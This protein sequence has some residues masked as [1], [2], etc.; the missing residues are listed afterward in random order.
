MDKLKQ[1]AAFVDVVEKGSLARAALEQSITP[2]MLGR[3]IDALEKRLGVKLM[4]RTTRHLTLTEQGSV[5]LDHCRKLLAELEFAEKI[6]SEGR[7]KAT[8]HLIV[9]AP[10]SFGRL[11]VAPHAPAFLAANPKVKVS[12]N[13]TDHVVDLVREGYELGIRI[14]GAI[15]PNFV[16]V[17][18][19]SNRRVVC[20]TPDYFDRNGIPRTLEDLSQHNCLAFNLQGGQQRGW[21]FQRDGRPVTVKVD[22]NLD[23]NDGELLH[24]WASEGLGLAWRSTWEIQ[25]QL[26]SG[27]LITVLDDYALPDY[28]IMAVYLQQRNLPAKVRFFIDTLKAVY[29][30]PGYWT[31]TRRMDN[32]ALP[33]SWDAYT[34]RS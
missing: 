2:V 28:D 14:G 12:F 17:K 23:C 16:A 32:P 26:A 29:A 33:G 21:Y 1:M 19:A 22:G 30:Q 27:Q 11:H 24:R 8:G 34:T 5:F 7:H 31:T 13:L 20:G 15:D 9:S 25:S 18:L 4:H 10:A 3:R 6:V